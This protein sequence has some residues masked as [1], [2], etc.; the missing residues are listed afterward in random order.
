MAENLVKYNVKCDGKRAQNIIL[1][2]DLD[3]TP[4]YAVRLEFNARNYQHFH[5][6]FYPF[7]P[8]AL[9][10]EQ[11]KRIVKVKPNIKH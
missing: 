6:G 1:S 11:E 4:K 8:Y 2:L 10:Y 9:T 5:F 3:G 7:Q